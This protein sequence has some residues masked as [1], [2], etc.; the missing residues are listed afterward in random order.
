MAR[1]RVSASVLALTLV[2]ASLAVAS[3]VSAADS[4]VAAVEALVD[5]IGSG[6]FD[7]LDGVVCAAE[8]DAVRNQFDIASQFSDVAG[9]NAG[10]VDAISMGI[11]DVLTELVTQ[12]SDE[13]RVWLRARVTL[14]IAP[15]LAREFVRSIAGEEL[16]DAN[17]DSLM[18]SMM[19]AFTQPQDVDEVLRLVRE[20]G[21][22]LVCDDFTGEAGDGDLPDSSGLVP[23]ISLEGLCGLITINQVNALGTLVFDSSVGAEDYCSY[24]ATDP[25]AHHSLTANVDRIDSLEDYRG[26]TGEAEAVSVAGQPAFVLEDTLYVGLPD[27]STL[28]ASISL[29]PDAA[30]EVDGVA[31]LLAFG[32]LL[33]SNIP[34]SEEP[35]P[36]D[37]APLDVAPVDIPSSEDSLCRLLELDAINALSPLQ[38]DDVFDG[39]SELCVY[40][41]SALDGGSHTLSIYREV[42]SLAGLRTIFPD[43]IDS[44]VGGLPAFSDATTLWLETG[45]GILAISPLFDDEPQPVGMDHLEFAAQVG[46]LLA[47]TAS[48]AED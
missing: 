8:Q 4:P 44:T 3:P 12:E 5:K 9:L 1:S 28:Q 2:L 14:T 34:E 40:S 37:P 22:W 35:D 45:T 38:Y 13:A 7:S 46:E 25:D 24:S 20:G 11:T 41:S 36:I 23:Q 19:S 6:G 48:E 30:T 17:L 47:A 27:G 42:F 29:D 43:G 31:Y 10:S 33:V 39:G 15:E 21:E 16:S 26:I 32:D 18:P